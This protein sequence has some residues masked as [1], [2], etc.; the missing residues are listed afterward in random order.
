MFM[1]NEQIHFMHVL[2]DWLAQEDD[3][4]YDI[5]FCSNVI[6]VVPGEVA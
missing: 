4:K 2:E 6:D 1:V 5:V 3:C